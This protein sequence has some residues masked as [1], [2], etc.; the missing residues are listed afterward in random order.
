MLPALWLV[1]TLVFLLSRALPATFGSEKILQQSKGYYASGSTSARES[2]YKDYLS[3]TGLQLP[4]FYF[5]ISTASEPD[6]LYRVSP[7]TDR[8]LLQQLAWQFSNWPAISVYYQSIKSLQQHLPEQ[9]QFLVAPLFAAT[10]KTAIL[11][12]TGK[13]D[14]IKGA[15]DASALIT[16]VQQ[17]ANRLYQHE[18]KYSFLVPAIQWH[19]ADNQYHQWLSEL[20]KGKLGTSYRDS[21]PVIEKVAEAVGTSFW[22]LILSMLAAFLISF[23]TSILLVQR[24][25]TK[26]QKFILSGL[27]FLDS[28]PLFVLCLLL[29]VLL[30][31]PDFLQLFP[32]YGLGYYENQNQ[33]W[34]EGMMQQLPY[35][36]LPILCLTIAYIPYLTNILYRALADNSQTDYARTARAKG[37]SEQKVIR[38]HLVRNALLPV[39]TLLSDFLPALVAGSVVIETIFAIPG[40]GRLLLESVQAR[41]YP[42]IVTIVLLVAAFKMLSHLLADIWYGIADPRIRYNAR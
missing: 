23:N 39:I 2:A 36:A 6:T 3:R 28:I 17:S 15:S 14:Q 7:E 27:Y 41:D 42:V 33:N 1:V 30:A 13:L 37:L 19:G 5:G 40:I 31:S 38:K 10:D 32:A 34:L 11:A 8:K 18:A 22:L 26:L 12:V 35:L 29:L 25:E 21:K 9:E 4:L 20:M 16:N 24:Q